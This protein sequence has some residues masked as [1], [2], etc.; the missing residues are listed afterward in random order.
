MS[1]NSDMNSH[2]MLGMRLDYLT[3][4]DYLAEFTVKAAAGEH[5]YCCVTNVHQ[6]VLTHD[7]Q[8]FR[9]LVNAAKFVISDSMI[10]QRARSIRHGVPMIDTIRGSEIMLEL[11]R[12]A[13]EQGLG[14]AL[15]GGKDDEVLATLK[16]K[17]LAR[18]PR[19]DIAFAYSPPFRALTDDEEKALVTGIQ[20]SG[21]KMI[22]VGLGCPKQE[23]WMA[24]HQPLFSAMMIGVGAAFDFNAG[25]VA[26]SPD[27]VHKAG[28]EW[29]YRLVSEPKRL[30]KRYFSTSPKF[31]WL[32]TLD[33][34]TSRSTTR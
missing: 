25:I 18:F 7:E 6:C 22:F 10:L 5:G 32:L 23:R 2:F 29:L 8:D 9:A 21:A 14:I 3:P 20:K 4:G 13:E 27:W 26:P 33:A 19:L 17:L 16:S 34:L 15:V 30:W 28:L 11:C 24:A 31:V 12:R 1:R